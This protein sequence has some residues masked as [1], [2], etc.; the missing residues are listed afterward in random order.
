MVLIAKL[1]FWIPVCL[2]LGVFFIY[3]NRWTRRKTILAI[4]S[5]FIYYFMLCIFNFKHGNNLYQLFGYGAG[6]VASVLVFIL[7]GFYFLK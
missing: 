3:D 7:I 1:V 4:P 2:Y 6:F 5:V